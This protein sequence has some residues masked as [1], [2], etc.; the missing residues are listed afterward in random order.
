MNLKNARTLLPGSHFAE[1]RGIFLGET[2][3][4]GENHEYH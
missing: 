3:L 4:N 2:I 1:G